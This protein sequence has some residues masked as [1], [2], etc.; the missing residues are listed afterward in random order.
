MYTS[1]CSCCHR[2]V[3]LFQ[4]PDAAVCSCRIATLV[5][6]VLWLTNFYIMLVLCPACGPPPLLLLLSSPDDALPCCSTCC[7]HCTVLCWPSCCCC[8]CYLNSL[9]PLSL[10]FL[11]CGLGAHH[12]PLSPHIA[13]LV[14]LLYQLAKIWFSAYNIFLLLL[15]ML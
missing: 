10:L 13:A 1:C 11:S 9:Q 7:H 15:K 12:P 3:P 14:L 6:H 2:F 5:L 8:C 4:G